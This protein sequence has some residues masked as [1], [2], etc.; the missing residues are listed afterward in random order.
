MPGLGQGKRSNKKKWHENASK[1]NM[2]IAAV[3]AVMTASN[4]AALNTRTAMSELL[5]PNDATATAPP[6]SETA[7]NTA[8]PSISDETNETRVDT[9]TAASTSQPHLLTYTQN[10]VQELLDEARLEGWREGMEEGYRMGKKKGV[11]DGREEY[12]KSLLEGHKLGIKNGKEEEQRKWLTE[13]HRPGMCVLTQRH[14]QEI[15]TSGKNAE[16]TWV[17]LLHIGRGW[18]SDARNG[19]RKGHSIEGS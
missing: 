7:T 11:K 12:E 6:A 16:L 1:F 4:T 17:R 10:E 18:A 14:M 9:A 5:P 15:E 2:N 19:S 13:G 3:N 8:N